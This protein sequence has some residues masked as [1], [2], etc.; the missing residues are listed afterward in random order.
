MTQVDLP[1]GS[2]NQPLYRNVEF[3]CFMSKSAILCRFE[4]GS[5]CC[6]VRISKANT[7]CNNSAYIPSSLVVTV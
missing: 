7:A 5:M 1:R 3:L 2:I 6:S 4:T